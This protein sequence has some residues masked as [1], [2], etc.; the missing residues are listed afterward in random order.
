MIILMTDGQDQGG[1]TVGRGR[2]VSVLSPWDPLCV[3]TGLPWIGSGFDKDLGCFCQDL[4]PPRVAFPRDYWSISGHKP[5][6]GPHGLHGH[7][8]S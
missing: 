8:S 3:D 6:T 2:G 4:S 7:V 1:P 5:Q